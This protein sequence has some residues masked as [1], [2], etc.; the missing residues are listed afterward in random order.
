MKKPDNGYNW[1][2][3]F[4]SCCSQSS[5]NKLDKNT[6]EAN[7]SREQSIETSGVQITTT[8]KPKTFTPAYMLDPEFLSMINKKRN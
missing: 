1:R 3:L 4:V 6:N 2:D 7:L 5:R 8:I